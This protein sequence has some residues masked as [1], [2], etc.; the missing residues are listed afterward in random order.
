MTASISDMF[1]KVGQRGTKTTLASPGKA[2]ADTSVTLTNPANWETST[3]IMCSFYQEDPTTHKEVDG[4]YTIWKGIVVGSQITSLTQ[5]YGP[6]GVTYP[7]GSIAVMHINTTWANALIAAL[8]VSH[9]QDG[10]LKSNAVNNTA[11]ADKAVTPGKMS[12]DANVETRMAETMSNSVVSGGVWSAIS[13]LNGAMTAAVAYVTGKRFSIAAIATRAFTASKDTYIYIDNSG[14]VQYSEV[15]NNAAQP[16]Q[17]A[18]SAWDYK[19]VTGASTITSVVDIRSKPIAVSNIDF[20]TFANNIKTGV[21][22][23]AVILTNGVSTDLASFGSKVTFTVASNCV[24]F[25]TVSMIA[26]STTDFEFKPL[27]Y[28]DGSVAG[29]INYLAAPGNASGRSQV[30]TY[31][32]AIPLTTGSHTLSAGVLVSSASTPGVPTDGATITALVLGN[33]TA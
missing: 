1:M 24:A 15:A 8:L 10:T 31:S 3:A 13:G 19:V 2:P 14:T 18:N 29:S 11:I 22:T 25:V 5:A 16:A 33:V 6:T 4:T 27:I 28:L 26:N 7:A 32:K 17:P 12:D 21:N 20:S 23:T 30:R 9:N